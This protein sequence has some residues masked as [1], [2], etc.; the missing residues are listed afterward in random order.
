MTERSGRKN[1]E[2]IIKRAGVFHR[3]VFFIPETGTPVPAAGQSAGYAA[4]PLPRC[5][6][7]D[8]RLMNSLPEHQPLPRAKEEQTMLVLSIITAGVLGAMLARAMI[9]AENVR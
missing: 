2:V 8:V 9:S 4:I 3:C 7:R 6:Q 1:R 5:V